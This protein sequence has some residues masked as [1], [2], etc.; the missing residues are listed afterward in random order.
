MRPSRIVAP[1]LLAVWS[2]CVAQGFA[3]E[4][5]WLSDEQAEEYKLDPAFYT[6]CTVVQ[7]ILIATSE[8]V[9]DL[10]HAEAAY[11]FDEIMKSIDPEVAQR[12]R[13]RKVLCLLIGMPYEIMV[14]ML[15]HP[16]ITLNLLNS[17]FKEYFSN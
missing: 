16:L 7:D 14:V 9:S 15:I 8:R 3:Y 11:Q 4:T 1:L 6:K 12:V 2:L 13:D 5:K 10:A 17:T